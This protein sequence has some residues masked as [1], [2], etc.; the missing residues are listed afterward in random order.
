[1]YPRVLRHAF[2]KR[3]DLWYTPSAAN[4]LRFVGDVCRKGEIVKTLIVALLTVLIIPSL[5]AS[6]DCIDYGDYL[7]WVGAVDT[8]EYALGVAVAGDYAY[9]ADYGS[10]LLVIN[11]SVPESSAIVGA[12]DTPGD[13]LG[14]AIAGNY[15]YVADYGSG[16]QVIDISV[17]ESPAIV[18]AVDTPGDA[19]GV[20]VAGSYAYVTDEDGGL[21]VID[22]SVP[23]SPAI[24][25][26]VDTPEYAL[27]V[28]IAGNYAYVAFSGEYSFLGSLQVIDISVPESPAI[29]GAVDTPDNALGVAVA[30]YYAYVGGGGSGLQVID[31]SVPESPAIVGAVDTPNYAKG[32]AAAGNY[33]YVADWDGGL[34]IAWRQC[35]TVAIEDDPEETTPDEGVP[36]ADLR[37]AVHPNPFNPQTT[38]TFSLGRDEW[39][40][41]SVFELTGRRVALLTDRN[42]DAGTH[43]LTWSGRDEAGRSMPSGTYL[44]RLETES[45]VGAQKLMLLR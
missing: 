24:L 41:V 1:M 33:A 39:A 9:V 45:A 34:Q 23:E 32:V 13:A 40:T 27:G 18:G 44:V 31:I 11:I 17:P 22:I 4:S 38:I 5:A 8:P 10:G 20:A 37:L 29:V 3:H 25:G 19:L 16:L 42:F 15:A 21:Q 2:S 7:H 6:Q 14:V 30:G 26:A 43:S 36:S 35:I 28:A 12:V